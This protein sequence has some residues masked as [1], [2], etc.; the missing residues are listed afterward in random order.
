MQRLVAGLAVFVFLAAC[1]DSSTTAPRQLHPATAL[2]ASDPPPPPLSGAG[3][4]FLSAFGGD[5]AINTSAATLTSCASGHPFLL[6]YTFKYL[7]NNTANNEMAHLDIT[8]AS[9]GQV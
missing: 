5:A 9:T 2:D 3:Q 7:V 4:G 8:G 6:N 1:S